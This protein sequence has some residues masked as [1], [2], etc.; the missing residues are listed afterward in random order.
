MNALDVDLIM[1][2]GQSNMAGR[3]DASEAPKVKPGTAYEFRAISDPTKI[4]PLAEPFGAHENNAASGV[5]ETTKTGSMVSA[6]AI[7]YTNITNRV[8]IGVSCSKGG[9]SIN[10]WQPNGPFLNDAISRYLTAKSWL[11]DN[12]YTI[13][14]KFMVWCQGETDGDNGMS[15]DEYISKMKRLVDAMVSAGLDRCY[16]VRIGNHRD[17]ETLYNPIIEA[18][19]DLCRSYSTA[20]L[21]STKFA[22]MSAAGLMKDSF[23]YTQ[24]GYNITGADAGINTAFHIMHKKEP[25][26]YDPKIGSLYFSQK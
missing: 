2:M 18:Q 12:G 11:T 13:K 9:T 22:S 8:M 7:E 14:N 15:K 10:V 21:V 3:G 6:F 26:M 16:I 25:C 23:H 4:Y 1:F 17:Y 5:S 24:N 20:V 19:T